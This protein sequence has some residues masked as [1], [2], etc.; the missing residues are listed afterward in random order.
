MKLGNPQRDAETKGMKSTGIESRVE[1]RK[2][3]IA[4]KNEL[5]T[6]NINFDHVKSFINDSVV[7][8]LEMNNI[9]H[10]HFE[11]KIEN[12]VPILNHYVLVSDEE[13]VLNTLKASFDMLMR[14]KDFEVGDMIQVRFHASGVN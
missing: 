13:G 6:F 4:M 9:T 10:D 8:L 3:S 5:K 12:G 2:K 7:E 1:F 11:E 14:S